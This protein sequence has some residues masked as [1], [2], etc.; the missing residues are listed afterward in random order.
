MYSS[1]PTKGK[2]SEE[3]VQRKGCEAEILDLDN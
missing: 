2:N 3:K 1:L